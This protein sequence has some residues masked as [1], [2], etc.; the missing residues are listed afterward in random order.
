MV[1]EIAQAYLCDS[2]DLSYSAKGR[3]SLMHSVDDSV[4][5]FLA[6]N[7]IQYYT[8]HVHSIDWKQENSNLKQA[9]TELAFWTTPLPPPPTHTTPPAPAEE[10]EEEVCVC[11]WGGGCRGG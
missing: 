1:L 8:G 4:L 6:E 9:L 10:E 11:V 2:I 3:S 5:L 7:S